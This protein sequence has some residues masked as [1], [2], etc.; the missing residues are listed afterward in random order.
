MYKWALASSTTLMT[1]II[2]TNSSL[3]NITST[4]T[5]VYT[6]D[7][8]DIILPFLF[9]LFV[10]CALGWMVFRYKVSTQQASHYAG[11][12]YCCPESCFDVLTKFRN[13]R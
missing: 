5:I 2:T 9:G 3:N 12:I 7:T 10:A 13:T 8:L 11:S 1:S 4:D 6:D